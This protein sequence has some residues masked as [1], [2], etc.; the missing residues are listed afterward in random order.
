VHW[1][2]DAPPLVCEQAPIIAPSAT[3]TPPTYARRRVSVTPQV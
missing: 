1:L 3:T 2:P